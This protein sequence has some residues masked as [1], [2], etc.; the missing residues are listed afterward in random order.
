M[1]GLEL[2]LLN[3]QTKYSPV[4]LERFRLF[5]QSPDYVQRRKDHYQMF[6]SALEK[7]QLE[8]NIG[9]QHRANSLYKRFSHPR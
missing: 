1:K 9:K 4:L 8:R 2:D 5:L 6:R 7:E 3:P